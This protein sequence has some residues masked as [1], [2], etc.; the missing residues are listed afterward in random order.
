M[1]AA[2][3]HAQLQIHLIHPR[4]IEGISTNRSSRSDDERITAFLLMRRKG[5]TDHSGVP[6][7]SRSMGSGSAAEFGGWRKK[8]EMTW[9]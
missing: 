9:F 7:P 1:E 5:S 8:G 3:Q 6:S 2:K 4:G